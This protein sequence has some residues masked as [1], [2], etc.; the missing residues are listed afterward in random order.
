MD[1]TATV[2]LLILVLVASSCLAADSDVKIAMHIKAHDGY[3][4]C[5][6]L[7]A[8]SGCGDFTTTYQGCGSVDVFTVFFDFEGCTG[9]EW[10]L[11]WPEEWGTALTSH[12]GEF[13]IGSIIYPGDWLAVTWSTCQPGP[14]VITAWTWL[15]AFSPGTVDP[16]PKYRIEPWG[17]FMGI[18]DCGFAEHHVMCAFGAGACG[19]FGGDPCGPTAV[20]PTTWGA[21]KGL[22]R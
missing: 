11:T 16:I 9:A 10:A 15:E 14:S 21:I 5:D 20:E 4:T 17:P 19:V 1:R 12:C 18:T 6:N 7:P 22:L 8:I 3:Q 2:A 13:A